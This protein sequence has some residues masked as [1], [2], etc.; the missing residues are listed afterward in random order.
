M[1]T[2]R[3][4]VIIP[5]FNGERFVARAIESVLAQ[6]YPAEEIVVVDDGSTDATP[7]VVAGYAPRVKYV[8]TSNRGVAAARNLGANTARGDWLAFLDADDWYLPDRLRWHADWLAK[9]P[10]LDFLTG[11]YEYRRADG[12]LIGRSMEAG[13]AGRTMIAKAKGCSEVVMEAGEFEA[14]VADHFGDTHT[15]SVPATTFRALGGYPQG[16]RVCEDVHFLIRL[17][18]RSLRAGV[19]CRP[20]GV[21]LIHDASATRRDGLQAQRENVRTLSDLKQLEKRFPEPVR[22]GFRRRLAHARANLGY[23]LARRG[24][25]RAAV[26]AVIPALWEYPGAQ[27]ARALASIAR[28]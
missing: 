18:S 19:V 25:R 1:T 21:Y 23:A 22:R 8:R 26:C 7:D 11:D 6:T 4:S 9:D 27:S 10:S 12:S 16:F 3:F 20:L 24:Q 28:G 5:V 17:V 15:L 14:F 2:P 13:A